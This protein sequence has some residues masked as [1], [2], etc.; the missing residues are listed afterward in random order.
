MPFLTLPSK[1]TQTS[2]GKKNIPKRK[3]LLLPQNQYSKL[4]SYLHF[5][6]VRLLTCCRK[7]VSGCYFDF[8]TTAI[9]LSLF[10]PSLY[11]VNN[12]ISEPLISETPDYPNSL[13]EVVNDIH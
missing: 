11:T 10:F 6:Q 9:L 3:E 5:L 12:H 13:V 1:K 2:K 7:N 8:V 4:A